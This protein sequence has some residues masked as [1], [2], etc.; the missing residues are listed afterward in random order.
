V[1][2][3]RVDEQRIPSEYRM[4]RGAGDDPATVSPPPA[5]SAAAPPGPGLEHVPT[6]PDLCADRVVSNPL[7]DLLTDAGEDEIIGV[8]IEVV[9][10]YPGGPS[11]A[12]AAVEALIGEVAPDAVVRRS[13][14]GRYVSTA[15]TAAQTRR[16]AALDAGAALETPEQPRDTGRAPRRR[17]TAAAPPHST[18]PPALRRPAPRSAIHRMWPNFEVHALIHRTVVTTKCE[19]AQRAFDA[20]GEGIVWAVLDSGVQAD[21]EHFAMH[22]TLTLPSGLQ[23]RS[24]VDGDPLTDPYGHGTHVAGIL[25]GERVATRTSPII[26]ATWYRDDRGSR[27]VTP[28]A[29]DRISGMAPRCRLLSCT[30]LRADGSGDVTALLEAI[31]YIQ[32]LNHGGRDLVVHGVNISVGHPFDPAWFGTGLTPVCREVDRLVRSGVV[33]VVAA[34]NTGYGRVLEDK[35]DRQM[36]VGFEMTI[37]DPGNTESAITVGSTS[38]QPHLSGISYFSSKG[39]TGDGRLKPDLV[40]PGERVVSAGAGTLLAKARRQVD[41]ASYVEDSGTSMAAPHVSGVAAGFLSV[42]PEYIGR[43]DEVKRILLATASDLGRQSTFQ[44]RGLVDAMRA[45]QSV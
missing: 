25:A 40:A 15:L 21:H 42:H 10:S 31:E 35:R 43:P 18:V 20:V 26:A 6:S 45:I 19:A 23:H 9:I 7:A 3:V 5:P 12:A 38:V 32:D 33:V 44:G 28:L 17:G 16:V 37:N 4:A 36:R 29:L 11:R 13:A 14:G 34:G 8:L 41:G 30:V 27:Q 39:P 22:S 24:F 2:G 1:E